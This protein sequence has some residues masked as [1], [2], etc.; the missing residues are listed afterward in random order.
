MTK[1]TINQDVV[2]KIAEGVKKT[3][4]KYGIVT[5]GKNDKKK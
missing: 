5:K 3:K 4:E 1:K 2:K